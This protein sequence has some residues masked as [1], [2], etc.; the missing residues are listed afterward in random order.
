M[1][2]CPTLLRPIDAYEV[3]QQQQHVVVIDTVVR[4][5]IIS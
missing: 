3:P 5:V 2:G 1:I 4:V